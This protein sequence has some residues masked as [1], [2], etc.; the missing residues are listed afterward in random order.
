V[1]L[2]VIIFNWLIIFLLTTYHERHIGV[3][4]VFQTRR[5]VPCFSKNRSMRMGR[6]QK[7]SS[8]KSEELLNIFSEEFRSY[9]LTYLSLMFPSMLELAPFFVPIITEAN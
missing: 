5:T 6:K 4:F 2:M 7:S 3:L 8:D 9:Y 1:L